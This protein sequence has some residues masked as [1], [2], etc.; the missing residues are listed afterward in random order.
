MTGCSNRSDIIKDVDRLI[1]GRLPSSMRGIILT[2]DLPLLGE[3]LGLDSV[4]FVEL[5]LMLED[6][7]GIR[8]P[9]DL[10][11][12]GPLTVGSIIDHIYKA[13]G[14]CT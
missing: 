11:E 6:Y 1:K 12:K 8:F 4:G 14:P 13:R 5:F 7:F 3:G 2:E 10:I 9:A